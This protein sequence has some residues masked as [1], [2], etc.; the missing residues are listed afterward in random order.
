MARTKQPRKN[1]HGSSP[2][3][4]QPSPPRSDQPA[5]DTQGMKE[6]L[7]A[8]LTLGQ[9]EQYIRRA[10]NLGVRVVE[11]FV[12]LSQRQYDEFLRFF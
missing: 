7:H 4:G 6:K 5:M 12:E 3:A 9:I 1:S 10:N 2:Q 8:G 11:N